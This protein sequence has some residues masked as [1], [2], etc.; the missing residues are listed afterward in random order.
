MRWELR[1]TV[2]RMVSDYDVIAPQGL[3]GRAESTPQF[4]R[5]HKI[6][7]SLC[8][9]NYLM[10]YDTL[11]YAKAMFAD[12]QEATTIRYHFRIFEQGE[13]I[14]EIATIRQRTGLLKSYS[15]LA[16]CLKSVN[17]Q[18]YKIGLGK[19]GVKCPIYCG[20]NQIA[21]INKGVTVTDN[22]DEYT[23]L[24]LDEPSAMTAV[25]FGL[26]LDAI[27]YSNRGEYGYKSTNFNYETTLNRDL[28]AWYDPAFEARC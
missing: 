10:Q 8:G 24:A 3:V 6:E 4:L 18:L 28:M 19:Q 12:L 27:F 26:Y 16:L 22:L 11:D 2:S 17:Y 15:Y 21:Q 7:F 14:G 1:Q 13:Q 23:L 9:H 20:K 5:G 25:F